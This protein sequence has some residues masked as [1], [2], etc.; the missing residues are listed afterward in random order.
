[1][2]AIETR[3][4]AQT[5]YKPARIVAETCNGQR[6]VISKAKAENMAEA[7]GLHGTMAGEECHQVVAQALA[8]KMN[9]KGR[10]ISGGTKRGMC[11][12]FADE[13]ALTE[14]IKACIPDLEHYVSTH[15]AGPDVRLAKLNNV[16][17]GS[18]A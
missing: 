8:D 9:W 5:N 13:T 4:I 1:M 2:I 18:A 16:L 6:L 11:F 15:G 14:A 3:Y 7:A 12:V 10:L 17:N